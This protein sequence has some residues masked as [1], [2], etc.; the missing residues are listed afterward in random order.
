MPVA[1]TPSTS[2]RFDTRPSFAPKTAARSVPARV[3]RDFAARER[4]T[5]A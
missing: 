3:S 4:M 1:A 5:S 2:A